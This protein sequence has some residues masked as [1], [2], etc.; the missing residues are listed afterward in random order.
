MT[1]ERAIEAMSRVGAL[2]AGQRECLRL[3]YK[4]QTSKQIART[5]SI[6]RHT[7]DQRIALACRKL[8]VNSRTQAALILAEHDSLK[9]GDPSRTP[10]SFAPAPAMPQLGGRFAENEPLVQ[11]ISALSGISGRELPQNRID[12]PVPRHGKTE[13]KFSPVRRLGWAFAICGAS[14]LAFALLV[15]AID[16]LGRLI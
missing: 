7:V 13:N 6:S 15:T 2:T 3:V 1:T 14:I 5:L 10:K 8:G 4:L 16:T 12:W 11:K 9:E